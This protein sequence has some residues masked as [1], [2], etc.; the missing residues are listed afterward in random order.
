MHPTAL[1][2]YK[3]TLK[4]LFGDSVSKYYECINKELTKHPNV[5]IYIS[6]NFKTPFSIYVYDKS[7]IMPIFTRKDQN[8]MLRMLGND[9][10]DVYSDYFDSFKTGAT[11]LGTF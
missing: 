7:V 1:Q 9:F 3:N 2:N 4:V 10:I 6:D 11:L 5:K 8:R